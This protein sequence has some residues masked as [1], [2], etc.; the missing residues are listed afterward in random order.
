M[1]NLWI[2]LTIAIGA[3]VM[4][5]IKSSRTP[6]QNRKL[7]TPYL[8][9]SEHRNAL[10]PELLVR[11]A[12]QESS[13]RSD[14]ITGQTK[15]SKGAIGIMQIV[16]RWHPGVDPYDP[17]DSINYAGR[18]LRQ[19]KNT[20]GSWKRALAAYNWGIGNVTQY[21]ENAWPVETQRYVRNILSNLDTEGYA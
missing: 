14:I 9:A 4:T 5:Q 7:Y 16:P 13:F 8:A 15:S 19:L 2:V 3:A 21:S 11:V 10:P 1:N 20:T 18:Y 12:D 6:N 17:I